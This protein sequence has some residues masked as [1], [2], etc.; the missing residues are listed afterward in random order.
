M[1]DEIHSETITLDKR[2]YTVRVYH[3]QD[4]DSPLDN[5]HGVH[6]TYR[7]GSRETLGNTP[8]D[9][10]EHGEIKERIDAFR[11]PSRRYKAALNGEDIGEPLIGL[12]VYAYVHSG[13]A[14]RTASFDC[15][16]DS[17]QS[18]FIYVTPKT[19][20]SWMG[21]KRLGKA[22]LAKVYE[23]LEAIVEEFSMWC[24]GECYYYSIED[25]YGSDVES[26]GGFIG[27]DSVLESARE[28]VSLHHAHV[29]RK[30]RNEWRGA[31]REARERRYWRERGV[32]TV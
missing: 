31:L 17:G 19:A 25:E 3:D 22:K 7:K 8:L 21:G 24:N 18:G 16:W 20:L 14:L 9:T 11:N 4:V 6:I 27:M 5:E 29:M 32:V 1:N 12:P 2:T 13:V 23:N 26:L 28:N 30:R 10:I 15:P